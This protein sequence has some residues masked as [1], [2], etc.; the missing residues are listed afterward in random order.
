M[1]R[2]TATRSV[3]LELSVLLGAVTAPL[4]AATFC[5]DDANELQATLAAAVS[6]DESDVIRIE[7]GVYRS[8]SPNG[9]NVFNGS[10]QAH[11]LEIS[12][13]WSAGCGLRLPGQRSSIDGEAVRP[14]MVIGGSLD[15]RGRLT[16]RNLQFLRGRSTHPDR[17][18]GLTINRGY[19]VVLASNLFRLNVLDHANSA[20]SGGLYLLTEGS[21]IV[22]GNVFADNDA[23]SPPTAAAGAAGMHC[24]ATSGFATFNHNTVTGNLAD[25]GT[26]SD[27]GGIRVYGL[28]NCAWTVA[29]NILWGNAGLDIA[30]DV[31][32]VALLSN[33]LGEPGGSQLPGS[34]AGNVDVDPQFVSAS[35]LRL[36]RSSPLV[37]AGLANPPGGTPSASFDGGP[38]LVGPGLDMGAYEQ[39]GLFVHGFDPSGFG[40]G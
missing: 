19:D 15:V 31:A 39:D 14:G 29:N 36:Q 11:D 4:Q 20:A 28:P 23:N 18:G 21:I 12:G 9:F 25:A 22:R 35:N 33:D 17:A 5:V 30:V 34:F 32:H 40:D 6:N 26:L 3:A 13:G 8:T 38:R 37:D 2:K 16:L 27:T 7:S 1:H 24:Y 10:S